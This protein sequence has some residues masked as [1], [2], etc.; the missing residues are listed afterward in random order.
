MN[1]IYFLIEQKSALFIEMQ[2]RLKNGIP[3]MDIGILDTWI[4]G[5]HKQ[6]LLPHGGVD[7]KI[8][9][10]GR[11]LPLERTEG[12]KVIDSYVVN[13]IPRPHWL[14]NFRER[15]DDPVE[16][17]LFMG[18]PNIYSHVVP[19]QDFR[20]NEPG[21]KEPHFFENSYQPKDRVLVAGCFDLIH[22]GHVH[23]LQE[24]HKNYVQPHNRELHVGVA[25]DHDFYYYK[26]RRPFYKFNERKTILEALKVVDKVHSYQI[27]KDVPAGTVG[28]EDGMRDLVHAVDPVLFVESRQKPEERIGVKVYLGEKGIPIKFV[29]SIDIHVTDILERIRGAK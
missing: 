25:N 10:N 17:Y 28:I 7:V 24:V 21:F 23:F 18:D 8:V 3:P 5:K 12:A 11:K 19:I 15:T 20:K 6:T 16:R 9:T 26:K 14:E 1:I 29:D 22:A 27:W 13:G 2:A 4:A